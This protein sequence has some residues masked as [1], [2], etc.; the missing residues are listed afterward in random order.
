MASEAERDARRAFERG[1]Q[2]AADAGAWVLA[3]GSLYLVDAL[4]GRLTSSYC[5]RGQMWQNGADKTM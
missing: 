5:D 1:V 2:S 4:R 3:T